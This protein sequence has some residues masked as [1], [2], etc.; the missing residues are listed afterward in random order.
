MFRTLSQSKYQ[1]RPL[2]DKLRRRAEYMDSERAEL[3]ERISQTESLHRRRSREGPARSAEGGGRSVEGLGRTID[4]PLS[5]RLGEEFG[6][7]LGKEGWPPSCSSSS[8]RERSCG[9]SQQAL[10]SLR[11]VSIHPQVLLLH[12][13]KLT[14]ANALETMKMRPNADG[15]FFLGCICYMFHL[16]LS[17][18][19]P[20]PFGFPYISLFSPSG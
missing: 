9:T 14:P 8:V 12:L 19:N 18:A 6:R 15:G 20:M 13:I 4:G 11:S 7:L 17:Y 2:S 1:D 16:R 5:G 10:G 3:I